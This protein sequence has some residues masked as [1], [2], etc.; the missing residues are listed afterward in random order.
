MPANSAE[1]AAIQPE[2]VLTGARVPQSLQV[3][4]A[5]WKAGP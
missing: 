5:V 3:E 4:G 2:A 1:A